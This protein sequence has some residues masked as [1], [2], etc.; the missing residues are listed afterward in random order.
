M[1]STAHTDATDGPPVHG[2]LG[3]P[4]RMD[5]IIPWDR[6]VDLKVIGSAQQ[7]PAVCVVCGDPVAAG[8]GVTARYEGRTLRFRCQGCLGRF[9]EDPELFLGGK[10]EQWCLDVAS[11]CTPDPFKRTIGD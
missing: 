3:Q 11:A 8:Q 4:F 9:T 6:F 7:G 10:T 1:T 5:D 2:P